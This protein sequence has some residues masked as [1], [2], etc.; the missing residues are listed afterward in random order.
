[1]L[2]VKPHI[3]RYWERSIPQVGPR[4]NA[5]GRRVYGSYE[6]NLLFRV[7][8][9]LQEARYTV[10]GASRRLWQETERV[11]P[12]LRARLAEIRD[13]LVAALVVTRS[14]RR[15]MQGGPVAGNG[16]APD[17]SDDSAAGTGPGPTIL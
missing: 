17:A 11:D 16:D 15:A 5:Y 1:M 2:G 14:S 7:R 3:L 13:D 8:H 10:D 6:V 9:L 12:R 4:K